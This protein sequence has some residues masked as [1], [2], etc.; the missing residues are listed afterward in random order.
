MKPLPWN[1]KRFIWIQRVSGMFSPSRNIVRRIARFVAPSCV[2]PFRSASSWAWSVHFSQSTRESPVISSPA[3]WS[4]IAFS[5]VPIR[6]TFTLNDFSNTPALTGLRCGHSTDT[7][8]DETR[9]RKHDLST[10]WCSLPPTSRSRR[11]RSLSKNSLESFC[12]VTL[13]CSP[14]SRHASTSW[15][16]SNDCI[17][18]STMNRKVRCSC[19]RRSP[20]GTGST[21]SG[22]SPCSHARQI[23]ASQPL[24]RVQIGQFHA[25][26]ASTGGGPASG[27][28]STHLRRASSRKSCCI[29]AFM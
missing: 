1:W 24:S 6:S 25:S 14:R 23:R 7:S 13:K 15:I 9:T 5:S 16:G 26:S 29:I 20:C 4:S 21:R 2:V 3:S 22:R 19:R 10:S 8:C 11:S 18:E 17:S 28:V 27:A 12:D